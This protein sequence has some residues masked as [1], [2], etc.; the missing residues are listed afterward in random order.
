[1]T[2]IVFVNPPNPVIYPTNAAGNAAAG[3]Q[4]Q[5]EAEHKEEI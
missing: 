5:A 1:M 3:V 2:G 4:A